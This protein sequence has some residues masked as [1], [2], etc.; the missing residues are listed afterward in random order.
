MGHC[1]DPLGVDILVSSIDYKHS[2]G[3]AGSGNVHVSDSDGLQ[4]I[5]NN[6][7]TSW[8]FLD[9]VILCMV[10]FFFSFHRLY[11]PSEER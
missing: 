7:S 8:Y 3:V 5:A 9:L 11:Q 2:G 6:V 1:C 4:V 10:T